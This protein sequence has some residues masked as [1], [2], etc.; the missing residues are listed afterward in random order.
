MRRRERS[1]AP[2]RTIRT[3]A[4]S[5]VAAI[6]GVIRSEPDDHEHTSS[7]DI[8]WNMAVETPSMHP[9]EAR[10]AEEPVFTHLDTTEQPELRTIQ[11]IAKFLNLAQQTVLL[12]VNR[13]EL[14]GRIFGEGRRAGGL[15]TWRTDNT[16]SSCSQT[17]F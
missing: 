14:E 11:G 9:D 1:P 15:E 2:P 12:A 13:L 6:H 17:V 4:M 8:H 16:P 5:S 10:Q 3:Q 7:N